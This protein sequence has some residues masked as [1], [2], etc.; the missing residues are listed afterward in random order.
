MKNEKEYK[1]GQ[2]LIS[3]TIFFIF[4]IAMILAIVVA[5]GTIRNDAQDFIGTNEIQQVCAIMRTAIG[6]IYV[7]SDYASS[8]NATMGKITVNLPERIADT[9]YRARFVDKN[10]VIETF[11]PKLNKTCEIGIDANFTGTTSGGRT[12][13]EWA[14]YG[15]G[16]NVITMSRV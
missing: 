9:S 6:K 13:L 14:R 15:N 1:S 7:P 2:I 5:F 12:Q 8:S 4:S 16:N 11:E 3:H 10:I